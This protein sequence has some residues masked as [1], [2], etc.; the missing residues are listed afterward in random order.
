MPVHDEE[1]VATEALDLVVGDVRDR[2]A[3]RN[4]LNQFV[5]VA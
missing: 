4:V 1:P 2:P 5:Q 3:V